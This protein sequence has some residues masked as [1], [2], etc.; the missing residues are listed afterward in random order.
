MKRIIIIASALM[1]FASFGGQQ[2]QA[3]CA[4]TNNMQATDAIVRYSLEVHRA[5]AN[6]IM[7]EQRDREERIRREIEIAERAKA[8]NQAGAEAFERNRKASDEELMKRLIYKP[9]KNP[10]NCPQTQVEAKQKKPRNSLRSY[11]TR[12]ENNRFE[13]SGPAHRRK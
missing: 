7:R 1:A 2:N 13:T 10:L 3:A 6:R 12:R 4:V 8:Y 11:D 5:I 9:R